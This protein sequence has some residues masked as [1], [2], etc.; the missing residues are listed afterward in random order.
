MH[1]I[2]LLQDFNMQDDMADPNSM[3]NQ[4]S[5]VKENGTIGV[6]GSSPDGLDSTM[7]AQMPFRKKKSPLRMGKR[8]YEFYNAPVTKFWAHAV[9]RQQ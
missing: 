3:T 9:S 5:P 2:F 6:S 4:L 8:V 7:F 1:F